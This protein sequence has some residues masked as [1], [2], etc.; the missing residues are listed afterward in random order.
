MANSYADGMFRGNIMAPNRTMTSLNRNSVPRRRNITPSRNGNTIITEH[1][2]VTP[3]ISPKGKM[4]VKDY[5]G[6]FK[7]KGIW[8]RD[9]MQK[10]K[11]QYLITQQI[12]N[13]K[14]EQQIKLHQ[15]I[16]EAMREE[17]ISNE[18]TDRVDG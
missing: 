10:L 4:K 18:N 11:D 12:Q 15:N 3:G 17:T 14:M 6:S 9:E 7:Q 2:V 16:A 1:R 5:Y 13:N 8:G